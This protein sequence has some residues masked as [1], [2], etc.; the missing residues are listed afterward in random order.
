[1]GYNFMY[2]GYQSLRAYDKEPEVVLSFDRNVKAQ[3]DLRDTIFSVDETVKKTA[4]GEGEF[5]F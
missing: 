1:M 4:S 3:E 5:S 2:T